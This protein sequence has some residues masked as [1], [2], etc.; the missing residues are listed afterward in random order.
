[1]SSRK[2]RLSARIWTRIK[3]VYN[4]PA[5]RGDARFGPRF[6][7]PDPAGAVPA[8]YPMFLTSRTIVAYLRTVMDRAAAEGSVRQLGSSSRVPVVNEQL[9]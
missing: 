3:D 4:Q 9:P 1:M 5:T 2:A 7:S 8:T 6:H